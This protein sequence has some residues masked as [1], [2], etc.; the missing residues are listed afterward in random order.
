MKRLLCLSFN[1]LRFTKA[2]INS[3]LIH[4]QK[5]RPKKLKRFIDL[6]NRLRISA[7]QAPKPVLKILIAPTAPTS[8]LLEN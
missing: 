1:D 6:K 8:R 3:A 2:K 7:I 5:P 4:K